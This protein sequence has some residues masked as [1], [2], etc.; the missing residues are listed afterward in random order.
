M[1]WS[2]DVKKDDKLRMVVDYRSQQ[3][4]CQGCS[5]YAQGA[6]P[7]K[8]PSGSWCAAFRFMP[9]GYYVNVMAAFR[10]RFISQCC[11]FE[12]FSNSYT[13]LFS[14]LSLQTT[15]AISDVATCGSFQQQLTSYVQWSVVSSNS[16]KLF[17][18][19]P[20]AEFAA[21]STEVICN[22]ALAKTF[23]QWLCKTFSAVT[24][25]L[26]SAVSSYSQR[27]SCKIFNKQQTQAPWLSQLESARNSD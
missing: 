9:K 24:C 12:L 13:M 15:Q 1:K 22:V 20:L 25:K 27:R 10:S 26:F 16:Y 19:L 23:Q 6:R 21:T 3:G 7:S 11:H 18:M 2:S 8:E 4:Y 14:M 5:S 17:S